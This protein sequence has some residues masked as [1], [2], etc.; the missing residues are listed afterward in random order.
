MRVPLPAS[1]NG[2]FKCSLPYSLLPGNILLLP[3]VILQQML[4]NSY[5]YPNVACWKIGVLERSCN[6]PK[7]IAMYPGEGIRLNPQDTGPAC[8][9]AASRYSKINLL[10][11]NCLYKNL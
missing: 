11:F 9:H 1:R 6:F 7:A 5:Y 3:L 2:S 10:Y 4:K 8:P